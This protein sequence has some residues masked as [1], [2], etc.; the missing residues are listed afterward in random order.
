MIPTKI[1]EMALTG[2]EF[3][4]ANDLSHIKGRPPEFRVIDN[5]QV[6]CGFQDPVD[7]FK[8][9]PGGFPF[10]F[11][12]CKRNHDQI[13]TMVL[14]EDGI[15]NVGRLRA[16]KT[17]QKVWIDLEAIVKP[18]MKVAEVKEVVE[19][20]RESIIGR[21]ERIGDVMIISRVLEPELKEIGP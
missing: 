15:I 3:N 12:Q 10:G 14:N 9:F 18:E 2:Q 13:K 8:N 17:G 5:Q 1:S 11:V 7:I 6:P 4:C 16:R 20:A 21:F 19:S